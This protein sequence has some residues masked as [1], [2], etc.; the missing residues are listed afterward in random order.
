MDCDFVIPSNKL[1]L[2]DAGSGSYFIDEVIPLNRINEALK[3]KYDE[4]S[5][6][7]YSKLNFVVNHKVLVSQLR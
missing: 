3:S 7:L 4:L 1:E 6:C 5:Y 2:L